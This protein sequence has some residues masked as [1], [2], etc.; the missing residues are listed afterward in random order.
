MSLLRKSLF[1]VF[2]LFSASAYAGTMNAKKECSRL[3]PN[4]ICEKR[5]C[6][7]AEYKA[8]EICSVINRMAEV[9]DKKSDIFRDS[10]NQR[11]AKCTVVYVCT[12]PQK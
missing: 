11:Y 12:F 10:E 5:A 7:R 6:K 9:T 1:G 3:E 8:N 4:F 2:T